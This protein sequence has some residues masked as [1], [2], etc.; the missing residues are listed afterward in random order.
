MAKIR[1]NK[2][3]K[4]SCYLRSYQGLDNNNKKIEVHKTIEI[5][6]EIPEDMYEA[7][8]R[9]QQL[10]FERSLNRDGSKITFAD[11]SVDFLAKQKPKLKAT[12]YVDYEDKIAVIN[13]EIGDIP[14]AELDSHQLAHFYQKL[15]MPGAKLTSTYVTGN[16]VRDKLQSMGLTQDKL[17]ELSGVSYCAIR[18]ACN[19][20]KHIALE[21]WM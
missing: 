8:A 14:F 6:P 10:I 13:D 18:K 11:Y 12:T 21:S 19:P 20:P 15:S 16:G 2:N 9:Q 5:P 17:H 4:V 1:K 3:G 7:Y